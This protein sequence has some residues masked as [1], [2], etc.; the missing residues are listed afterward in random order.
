MKHRITA[1][2]LPNGEIEVFTREVISPGFLAMM[3]RSS[4]IRV[5]LDALSIQVA[6]LRWKRPAKRKAKR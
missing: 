6:L 1:K 2:Y 3:G 5:Q 4:N